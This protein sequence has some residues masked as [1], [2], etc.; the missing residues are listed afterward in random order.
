M[1]ACGP[2][3]RSSWSRW[4]IRFTLR[5]TLGF[6]LLVAILCSWV[7]VKANAARR[8]QAAVSAIREGGGSVQYR[9]QHDNSGRTVPNAESPGPRWVRMLMG[10]DFLSTVDAAYFGP[11]A[12]DPVASHLEALPE[13]EHL[14]LNHSRITD[15]GLAHLRGL[16]KLKTIWL[17]GTAI[18][19]AAALHLQQLPR[20]AEL[21]LSGTRITDRGLKHLESITTLEWIHLT[22]TDVTHDGVERLRR[23]LPDIVI[24]FVTENV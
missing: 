8:Q 9:H 3:T 10:D 23:A 19:D 7:G 20:L 15:Q 13:L 24:I 5:T 6:V 14:Y 18:T 1:A 11:A 16:Q 12:G 17:Q 2:Q 22:G 21:D 4:P